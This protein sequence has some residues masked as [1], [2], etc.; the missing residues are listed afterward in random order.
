VSTATLDRLVTLPP[1]PGM[2]DTPTDPACPGTRHGSLRAYRAHGCCCAEVVAHVMAD[3][4]RRREQR[5][6]D[7]AA[8]IRHRPPKEVDD[9]DVDAAM[10]AARRWRPFPAGLTQAE[11]KAV[12][13]RLRRSGIGSSDPMSSVEISA[14]MSGQVSA[15]TVE[16]YL[17]AAGRP[18]RQLRDGRRSTRVDRIAYDA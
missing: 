8:G 10:W 13:L 9:L 5:A 11:L 6:A 17:T 7:R 2:S 1:L 18:G 16:R 12:A 3:V 15:R 14:R 4:D